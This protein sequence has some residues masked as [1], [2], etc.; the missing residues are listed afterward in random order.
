MKR[1]IYSLAILVAGSVAFTANGKTIRDKAEFRNDAIYN[2]TRYATT[3]N[4]GGVMH[5]VAD[6]DQIYTSASSKIDKSDLAARWSIHYSKLENAY[7]LYNLASGKFVTGNQKNKAVFT[8]T[9]TDVVPLYNE[10]IRYWMIDCGGYFIGMPTEYAGKA[11]FTDGLTK[12]E[13]REITGFFTIASDD[14]ETLTSEQ[15]QAI[16]A[17]IMAGRELKLAEYREFLEDAENVGTSERTKNYLGAYDLDALKY[18]LEHADQYSLAEIEELYQQAILSRFPKVDCYY[19][20]RSQGGRPTTYYK[21]FVG[22]TTENGV[23]SREQE[24][25]F[26]T[27]K[28]GFTDDLGLMRFWTVDGDRTRVKIQ[29]PATGMYLTS[30]NSGAAVGLTS[31]YDE[32]YVFTL[33]TTNVK[34]RYY[35]IAQPEKESW[36]TVAGDNRLVGYGKAENYMRF[37]IEPVR[38]ISVPV[39]ANGYA[40]VCVPCGVSLP[41]G[42]T[43]YT[44]TDFSGGKAYVEQLE[45]T[46]HM[47]TPF[48]VKAAAGA[49]TVDLVVENTTE[50]IATAMAGTTVVKTDAPGRYV[51]TFSA[52][53]ISFT[54]TEEPSVMPGAAYIVSENIGEVTTVMGANP[55]AG[56]EE[57]TS[58]EAS[59]LELFDLQGRRVSETP[60]SGIYINAATKRALRIN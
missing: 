13:A 18:A 38:T 32:A 49:K 60:R 8:E 9:A 30:A 36:I 41:E 10:D 25:T 57:I 43:A 27:A 3:A 42:V 1:L 40:S 53:G 34:Q 22:T 17:K 46:I 7:Y 5:S 20:M 44:V 26:G 23:V 48:I 52:E 33:E 29:F 14:D 16:E 35:R 12:E 55:E 56:I 2:L 47:N 28:D 37:Y 58:E 24:P 59:K 21:V 51:P 50:W 6:S 39:D 54:Y 4:G 15:I 45:G 19:R 31:S 11:F